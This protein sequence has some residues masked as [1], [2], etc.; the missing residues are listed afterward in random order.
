MRDLVEALIIAIDTSVPA[1]AQIEPVPR[2]KLEFN[3]LP[4]HWYGL[5]VAASTNAP[6]VKQYFGR[7]PNPEVGIIAAPFG[8]RIVVP[9]TPTWVSL[10]LIGAGIVVL[11]LSRLVPDRTTAQHQPNPHDVQLLGQFRTLI[12]PQLVRF[13]RS[14]SFRL[15]FRRKRFDPVEELAFDWEGAHFEFQ[16]PELNAS[17]QSVRKAAQEL[18]EKVAAHTYVDDHN[19]EISH[20]LTRQDER[21]GIQ[22]NTYKAIADMNNLR[23]NTVRAIDDF[24]RLARRTMPVQ[25][26]R[27]RKGQGRP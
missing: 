14:H 9:E 5:I 16:D 12:T 24:E 1:D 21:L 23:M 27:R 15:P 3:K 17:L 11:V 8:L 20:P 13:L 25:A 26:S 10:V 18:A 6:Y 4:P 19:R 2:D 7:H 22:P